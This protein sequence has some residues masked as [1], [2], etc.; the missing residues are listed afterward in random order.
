MTEINIDLPLPPLNLT[1]EFKVRYQLSLNHMMAA[2]RFATRVKMLEEENEGKE[3][4]DFFDEIQQYAMAVTMMSVAALEAYYNELTF[5]GQI[6]TSHG[7]NKDFANCF[8]EKIE[9]K[10]TLV[11]YSEIYETTKSQKLNK[12]GD[13]WPHTKT[14]IG[15]RDKLIHFCPE[16][17]GEEGKHLDLSNELKITKIST[18]PFLVNEKQL[19]P[20]A[21]ASY[22][23]CKWALE[24][25]INFIEEFHNQLGTPTEWNL[26]ENK[27]SILS[28]GVIYPTK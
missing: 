19:F 24:T 7:K 5:E 4:G 18:S 2:C 11:K 20:L 15:V 14:L 8:V 6:L 12:E 23:F 13:W 10:P 28:E 27:L 9:R 17:Y 22:S 26:F 16:W 3:F 25:T 1:A 21:W